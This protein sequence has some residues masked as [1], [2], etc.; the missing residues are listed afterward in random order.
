METKIK[1]RYAVFIGLGSILDG[2]LM[3][4]T[5]GSYSPNFALKCALWTSL[6]Q[7]KK[8]KMKDIINLKHERQ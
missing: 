6:R 3:V 1:R 5:I 2:L 4:L 8:T 7:H